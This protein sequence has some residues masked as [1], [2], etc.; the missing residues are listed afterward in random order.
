M[1]APLQPVRNG[2]FRKPDA[3]RGSI[4]VSQ[5]YRWAAPEQGTIR[6]SNYQPHRG[7]VD[8]SRGSLG[9]IADE[10]N[11]DDGGDDG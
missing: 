9:N 7:S 8:S 6:F 1:S 10:P 11:S 2:T 5:R 4:R 3:L